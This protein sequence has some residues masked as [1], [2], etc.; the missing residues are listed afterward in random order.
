[1][2]KADI[3][4][5]GGS[6]FYELLPDVE[7]VWVETPYGAPSDKYALATIDGKKVAFLPRHGKEH[8]LPP[9]KIN[10]RANLW[11]MKKLGV[12]RIIGPCA[13]GSL[14]SSIKPGD[15][16]VTDQFVNRTWGRADTFFDG[17]ITT[18]ISAA[19][20][21]CSELRQIAIIEG[22]KQGIAIHPKGTV[23]VIQGPRFSTQAESREFQNHGWD[24]INMTQYPEG[25]LARELGLCYVNIALVTDYDAGLV[26]AP[27]VE[28]V[29]HAE[30]LK[31]FQANND[32]LKELLY[33]MIAAVPA[34]RGEQCSCADTL[35]DARES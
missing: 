15:F 5:F 11:G 1:M 4:I 25:M 14:K 3:G 20:P 8:H 32:Q 19:H 12:T 10:Y 16:V 34:D 21:Y 30:V 6:G 35:T 27:G 7:E 2:T 31:V 22:Q 26:D 23:V 9:H 24:V 13:A 17:P 29:T 33:S 18:H 28:A